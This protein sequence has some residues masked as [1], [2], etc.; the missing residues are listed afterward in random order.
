MSKLLSYLAAVLF[1]VTSVVTLPQSAFAAFAERP[2]GFVVMDHTSQVDGAMYKNLRSMVKMPYHFPD[3]KIIDGGLPQQVVTDVLRDDVRIDKKAMS[4][5]AEK[6]KVDVLVVVRIYSMD[7]RIVNGWAGSWEDNDSYVLVEA[8]AD[9]Y[10]YKKDGNKFLKKRLRERDI[11]DMGNYE[12]PEE[13]I[14][15]ALSDIVNDMEGRPRI[16]S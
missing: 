5:L 2:V 6:S 3:Y 7:E 8:I 15:W 9:F 1:L 12:K 13:T 11:K 10:V 4:A 14:K 16:G